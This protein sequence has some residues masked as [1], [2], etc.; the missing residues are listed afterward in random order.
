MF[1]P[2][3]RREKEEIALLKETLRQ[4]AL[5]AENILENRHSDLPLSAYHLGL[6][7]TIKKEGE[8]GSRG[9]TMLLKHMRRYQSM[10]ELYQRALS[11]IAADCGAV[12][13]EF[14][15]CQHPACN[16]SAHAW[17]VANDALKAGR[18]LSRSEENKGPR[19]GSYRS[20]D[21]AFYEV[22]PVHLHLMWALSPRLKFSE[23]GA[24]SA[25]HY[26]DFAVHIWRFGISVYINKPLGWAS[27]LT[28]WIP[29]NRGRGY[30]FF[31]HLSKPPETKEEIDRALREAGYD[32]EAVAE[33]FRALAKRTLEEQE[34]R[35]NGS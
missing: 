4:H 12:C 15:I 10:M 29:S 22:G 8:R 13:E 33:E 27:Y 6:L 9:Y 18:E 21:R 2:F 14:E 7:E 28:R 34:G 5:I 23:N 17:I 31:V 16:S 35:D 19:K 24:R 3:N 11:D 1:N 25:A 26:L 20:K 30:H 32:P